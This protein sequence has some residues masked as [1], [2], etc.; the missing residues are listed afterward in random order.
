MPTCSSD[1]GM[2]VTAT[3]RAHGWVARRHRVKTSSGSAVSMS[4]AIGIAI[5]ATVPIRWNMAHAISLCQAPAPLAPYLT[6]VNVL[7]QP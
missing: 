2:T 4:N 6:D 1:P 7:P 3:R 5:P